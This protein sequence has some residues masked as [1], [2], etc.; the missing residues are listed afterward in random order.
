MEPIPPMA[1][2]L[3]SAC[4]ND[5]GIKSKAI[6]FNIDFFNHFRTSPH[7]ADI[8]NL[9]AIGYATNI[10]LPRR[11]LINILKFTKQ[12]LLDIREKYDPK[13]IG[14]SIFTSE[15]VDFSYILIAYIRRYLPDTQIV[16]GGRGLENI[17]AQTGLKHYEMYWK[18]GLADL[19]V[20]GDA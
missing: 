10:R 20:V 17:H 16:L 9:F 4:L 5:A 14:L 15:S 19:L 18:Y 3:L 2:V 12:Y 6:D 11:V 7:W 1:P 8:H 13:Y